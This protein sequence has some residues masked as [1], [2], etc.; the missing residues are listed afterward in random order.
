MHNN[1]LCNII[2]TLLCFTLYNIQYLSPTTS[3]FLD[4]INQ[5]KKS[6]MATQSK[7]EAKTILDH[8]LFE[9]YKYFIY[10]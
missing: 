3:S 4:Q 9:R 10:L 1:P 8:E 5:Y 6:V 2:K 7:M